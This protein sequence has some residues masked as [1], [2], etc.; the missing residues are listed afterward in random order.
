[1]DGDLIR[2][3]A[4]ARSHGFTARVRNDCVE[5]SIPYTRRDDDQLYYQTEQVRSFAELRN[6]LGY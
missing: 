6:A 5:I 4:I 2:Y 3:A 1:M